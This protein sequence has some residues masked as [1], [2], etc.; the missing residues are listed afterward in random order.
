MFQSSDTD[1]RYIDFKM[2]TCYRPAW[3]RNHVFLFKHLY[4]NKLCPIYTQVTINKTQQFMHIWQKSSRSKANVDFKDSCPVQKAETNGS[5]S[6]AESLRTNPYITRICESHMKTRN[7]WKK[8]FRKRRRCCNGNHHR[9]VF[10]S[11][12]E[13][14]EKLCDRSASTHYKNYSSGFSTISR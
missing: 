10:G 3:F 6:A 4:Q 12:K 14:H 13:S 1:N 8:R 11:H 5:I 7:V 2:L 9:L